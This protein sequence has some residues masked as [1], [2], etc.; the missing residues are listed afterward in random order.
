MSYLT[1]SKLKKHDIAPDKLLIGVL[2]CAYDDLIKGGAHI[3][4]ADVANEVAYERHINKGRRMVAET[5]NFFR[6]QWYTELT[7]LDPLIFINKAKEEVNDKLRKHKRPL[8]LEQ[9]ET[10]NRLFSIEFEVSA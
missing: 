2:K 4:N 10:L 6:S 7:D 8:T 5:L 3:I 9:A 1:S